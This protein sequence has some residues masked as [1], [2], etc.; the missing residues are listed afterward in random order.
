MM[1]TQDIEGLC[2]QDRFVQCLIRGV[3]SRTG[4]YWMWVSSQ[5]RVVS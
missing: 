2:A 3:R 4:L 1:D 5:R